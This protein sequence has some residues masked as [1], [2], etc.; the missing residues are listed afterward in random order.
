[1]TKP[2][3]LIDRQAVIRE[4]DLIYDCAD[5]IFKPD[6]HCCKP[7]DCKGC[8]WWQTRNYIRDQIVAKIPATDLTKILRR[9][10]TMLN[11]GEQVFV[12]CK[13][14]TEGDKFKIYVATKEINRIERNDSGD[15]IYTAGKHHELRFHRMD[16][17]VYQTLG[18]RPKTVYLDK[19]IAEIARKNRYASEMAAL[20]AAENVAD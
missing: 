2:E 3:D 12:V 6:D 20:A 19:E 15:I 16:D 17:G 7:E 8:K 9:K 13:F 1:M 18:E 5:M 10:N 14:Y 11:I 4:L